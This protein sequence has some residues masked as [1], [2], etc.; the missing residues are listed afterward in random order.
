MDTYWTFF[1]THWR[2]INQNVI[3][4]KKENLW[5]T[6]ESEINNLLISRWYHVIHIRIDDD[7][8]WFLI[9]SKWYLQLN[10]TTTGLQFGKLN[11]C[12]YLHTPYRWHFNQN[13]KAIQL[14]RLLAFYTV[15]ILYIVKSW[16]IDIGNH[17]IS[18]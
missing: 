12:N 9:Y 8:N 13:L 6:V 7:D 17:I 11:A 14:R 1:I 4:P 10:I 3:L 16:S 2:K 5:I 18:S 15:W